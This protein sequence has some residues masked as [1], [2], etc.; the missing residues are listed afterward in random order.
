MKIFGLFRAKRDSYLDQA[1]S[2]VREDKPDA[3]SLSASAERVWKRI[4]ADEGD[5]AAANSP[6]VIQGCADIRVLLPA[7]Y[8]HEL[9]PAR[10]SIVEDHLRECVSCRSYVQGRGLEADA[11]RKW[12][13]GTTGHGARWAFPRPFLVAAAAAV[14]VGLV[15]AG[16]SWYFA[17]LPGASARIGSA[18]GQIFAVSAKNI[19]MLKPGD[20][21]DGEEFIRTAAGSHA[22]VKLLD[23]SDVEM[24][25]RAEFAV[26]ATR[27]DTTI[28]LDQGSII[29][30]AAKRHRG[31]LY[32]S[33]P[34]CRVAVTGTMFAVNSGTK[35]SRVTVIEGEVHVTH[36]GQESILHSG[37]QLATTQAV[38]VVPVREEIAWSH[39]LD[40]ELAL[41]AEFSKLREKFEQ[42]PT[43]PA[44]Y[45]S[46]ILPLLPQDTVLYV[47]IPNLGEALQQ[48]NQIFQQQLL[49]SSVLQ[50]WWG[51]VHRSA[52]QITPEDLI[53]QVRAISQFLGDE[54]VITMS[55]D[56]ENGPVL[57]SEIRQPGL[58]DFL[59]NHLTSAFTRRASDLHVVNPQSLASLPDNTHGMVMLVRQNMLVVGGDT[60]SVRQMNA[61]ISGATKLFGSSDFAQRILSVYGGGAETLVAINFAAILNTPQNSRSKAFQTS[62][63][64][65]VKYLVAT[66][67]ATPNHGDNRLTLEFAGA[68]RGIPSWLA[69][70]APMGSLDYV[71]AN[72]G[73]AVSFVA[74][75]PALMLDDLVSVIGSSDPSFSNNL[76][77]M[78]TDLGF[79]LRNDLA[80]TLNGEMTVALDGPLLPTPSW[81]I[82]VEV[83]NPGALQL[84]IEKSI[85]RR[86]REAQR[87]NA[88][89][90]TLE[91]Q[92]IGG[93]TFYTIHML[94]PGLATECDYTFADGYMLLAP[95]RAL[96]LAALDTHADGSSL[97][98]S[99]SFRSLL[100]SDNQANF[101]GMLYQNLSP[102]LKPLASQ[103]TS[104]Q[105]AVLQRL[106]ADSKPSVICAYGETDRIEVATNGNLLDLN[107]GMMTLFRLLGQADRGTSSS[108]HP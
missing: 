89:G 103:V 101:S 48:A 70:P 77:E 69:E 47:S 20:E 105:F 54:V 93:R 68:R 80:S 43:P 31:H 5:V 44:R 60:N 38:A 32:V 92:Q 23:G 42:I 39:D 86:N 63:F 91:Q 49:Q 4:Q 55:R 107:P 58:E 62:G 9:R 79:D 27:R 72:A 12:Q 15:W 7:F 64:N 59:Q 33:A 100:P 61:Q 83:D 78:N 13:M 74:K 66:R 14:L 30:H 6:Q 67:S 99:A 19:R 22:S 71:S 106:A 21:V 50:Q 97:A 108:S 37:D 41:L 3:K 8:K 51:Q 84:V 28:Q 26:S 73:A 87:S 34:D 82:I 40:H 17:G 35:G 2:Q 85:Q 10:A 95:S 11:A 52:Q 16:S 57:L 18:E 56:S 45:E 76:A 46:N 102:I 53:A 36:A 96:L 29:V 65:N 104:Q 1:I 24:N 88:P 81:K 25:Q 90:V 94:G 75:Q 98:R